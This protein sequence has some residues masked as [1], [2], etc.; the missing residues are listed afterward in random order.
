MAASPTEASYPEVPSSVGP[1]FSS[2]LLRIKLSQIYIYIYLNFYPP[3]VVSNQSINQCNTIAF[4]PLS[5][6]LLSPSPPFPLF[7]HGIYLFYPSPELTDLFRIFPELRIPPQPLQI[8][9]SKTNCCINPPTSV[10]RHEIHQT[11][12]YVKPRSAD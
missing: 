5:S 7:S 9:V 11:L 8:L 10:H 12:Y 3:R 1:H 4:P 6:I 2:T